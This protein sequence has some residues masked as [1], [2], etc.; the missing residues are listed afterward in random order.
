MK[1]GIAWNE[2]QSSGQLQADSRIGKSDG[3]ASAIVNAFPG[4]PEFGPMRH[5]QT[6][7]KKARML[8]LRAKTSREWLFSEEPLLC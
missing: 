6:Y 4:K 1:E 5:M 7:K 8:A 2:R 3:P